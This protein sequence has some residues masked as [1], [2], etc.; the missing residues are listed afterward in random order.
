MRMQYFVYP[1][2]FKR[3]DG[4][5]VVSFPDF[6]EALTGASS[7]ASDDALLELA[8][9]ALEEAVLGRLA[10]REVVPAPSDLASGHIGVPLPPVTAARALVDQ[11]R[12]EADLSQVE[13]A[14]RMGK[15]EKVVRRILDG[16][17][18]VKIETAFDALGAMGVCPVLSWATKGAFLRGQVEMA[19]AQ[20][21]EFRV[22]GT[23][24][25]VKLEAINIIGNANVVPAGQMY[26]FHET[27]GKR[28]GKTGQYVILGPDPDILSTSNQSSAEQ[29]PNPR[30][31]SIA[32]PGYTIRK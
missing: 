8:Q 21:G 23:G 16:M 26:V 9:D 24:K 1:A 3:I 32:P 4:E 6:P 29:P 22:V 30:A 27:K 11:S 17:H 31:G 15:D 2:E 25:F 19:T 13:L 28:S 10:N 7:E 5:V 18:S 14:A 12:R 20:S